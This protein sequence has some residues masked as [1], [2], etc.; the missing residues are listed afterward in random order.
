MKSS[1]ALWF[2]VLICGL[3]G[4][5]FA[6]GL[7]ADPAIEINDPV[8]PP[9][10]EVPCA[11]LV[12]AL[13]PFTFTA[14]ANGNGSIF[15]EVNPSG[16]AFTD[17]NVQTLGVF[18]STTDVVCTSNVFKC[19]VTFIGGVVTNMFFHPFPCEVEC[20]TSS[21]P[22]GDVINI[23]LGD[24][25]GIPNERWTPNQS[26]TAIA[27]LGSAQ[28]TSFISTPE[29]SSLLLFGTGA[30]FAMRRKLKFRKS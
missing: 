2:L 10:A 22:P 30:I 11:P 3:S 6:D 25:T 21:F 4:F 27:N 15:F 5:A 20:G 28:T 17:L 19:D 16:P 12:N 18:A 29:P 1:R 7:P 14:D 8:C 23:L 13:V 24:N 9:T 26:F